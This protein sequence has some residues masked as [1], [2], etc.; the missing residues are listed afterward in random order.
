MPENIAVFT[1]ERPP[2]PALN[3]RTH[4][5]RAHMPRG[6]QTEVVEVTAIVPVKWEP[7]DD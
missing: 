5:P 1:P 4:K 3:T 6:M 7:S 2:R